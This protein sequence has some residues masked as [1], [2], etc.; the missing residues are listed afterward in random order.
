M[1]GYSDKY[2]KLRTDFVDTLY[3]IFQF[4]NIFFNIFYLNIY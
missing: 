4:W 1:I 2:F 3:I